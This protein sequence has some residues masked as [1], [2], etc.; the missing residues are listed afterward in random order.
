MSTRAECTKCRILRIRADAGVPITLQMHSRILS[1]KA[2]VGDPGSDNSET[3]AD[4]Q[5]LWDWDSQSFKEYIYDWSSKKYT[6]IE[7]MPQDERT[8]NDE[9]DDVWT[10][11]GYN[12]LAEEYVAESI[13]QKDA[14]DD[15]TATS[16]L[17]DT[18][19]SPD[20]LPLPDYSYTNPADFNTSLFSL[21]SGNKEYDAL[22]IMYLETF[23]NVKVADVANSKSSLELA[24]MDLMSWFSELRDLSSAKTL[25]EKYI[26]FN[27]TSR[28]LIKLAIKDRNFGLARLVTHDRA[29]MFLGLPLEKIDEKI[30]K[31]TTINPVGFLW[32]GKKDMDI[33]MKEWL[34]MTKNW[35]VAKISVFL[36]RKLTTYI[37]DNA[38]I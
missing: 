31:N 33:V 8:A 7:L 13:K 36:L 38:R 26:L 21:N 30:E 27:T 19:S 2:L 29:M 22:N 12:K 15:D 24:P 6:L 28:N 35:N 14:N 9:Y 1:A 11:N 34:I 5:W 3:P 10:K 4:R 23:K 37:K 17:G 18:V 32:L 25:V 16:A 20:D